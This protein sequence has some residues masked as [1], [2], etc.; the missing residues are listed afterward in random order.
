VPRLAGTMR[1]LFADLDDAEP[2]PIGSGA[3]P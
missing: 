3:T 1:A 2:D